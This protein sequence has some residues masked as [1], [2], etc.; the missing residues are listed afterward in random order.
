MKI[1]FRK[2]S[3]KKRI[4]ARTSLKRCVRHSLGFKMPRGF[5]VATNPK[6]FLYNKV[7]NR[8]TF[9]IE[10]IAKTLSRNS[11]RKLDK[12]AIRNGE[13]VFQ[14]SPQSFIR[15]INTPDKFGQD[16]FAV[17]VIFLGIVC[18]F[19]SLPV[20]LLLISVG[21]YW[22]YRISKTPSYQAKDKLRKAKRLLKSDKFV[23]AL[24]LL[25][26]AVE[27]KG[28][29]LEGYYLLG[30][31]Q[32]MVGDYEKSI[33]SLERYIKVVS[34]D[35]DAELILALNYYNLARFGDA[36]SILQQF[37]PD[38]HDYLIVLLLLGDCF[39]KM[40]EYE[41][42]IETLKRGSTRKR[43]LDGRL[44]LLHYLLGKAY[45]KKGDKTRALR[46]FRRVY[47]FDTSFRDVEKE[48]RSLD[49]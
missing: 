36:V 25:K 1:G 18:L 12:S 2:P 33:E 6:K 7:Y 23:E 35:L 22:L 43:N 4:S 13:D 47:A 46:E 37:P 26:E 20:A 11:K 40:K 42:A 45:K 10:D 30:V 31:T 44:V 9:G 21:M 34:N 28:Q 27:N 48:I 8:T 3:L 19:I 32:Y 14:I 5:G 24:P 41:V 38:Y 16:G 15:L 29:G 17:L 39:L 49:K